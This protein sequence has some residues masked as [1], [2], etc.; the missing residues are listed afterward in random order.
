MTSDR[1]ASSK[2]LR[3]RGIGRPPKTS[4]EAIIEGVIALLTRNADPAV[5]IHQIAREIGVSSMAIYNYF[6]SRN[7]LMQ[8]VTGRLMEDC[9]VEVKPGASWRERLT[10][11]AY[12]VR[13]HFRRH[14]Y[15]VNFLTWG[16]HYSVAWLTTSALIPDALAAGGLTGRALAEASSWVTNVIMGAISFEL[17]SAKGQHPLSEEDLSQIPVPYRAHTASMHAYASEPDFLDQA[18]RFNLERML[19]A[20][21]RFMADQ[22]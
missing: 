16:D 17:W 2:T 3:P 22:A 5:S 4:R 7:A 15:L 1:A 8:A 10:A 20:L 18:F 14:P 6:E 11:W 13:A 21:A 12:A 9:R 19:D